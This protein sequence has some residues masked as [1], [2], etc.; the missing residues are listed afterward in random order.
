MKDFREL[1]LSEANLL[2]LRKK[3]FLEPTEIQA[4]AIPLLMK[5]KVDIIAQAQTGTGKTAAFALPLIEKL[6]PCGKVQALILAPTRELVLQICAEID[7]LKGENPMEVLPIYGGSPYSIQLRG[8]KSGPSIVVG[9]PGRI[10]DHIRRGTLVLEG[11][12]FFILDEAD[13]MLNMGFIEDI[14]TII[15]HTPKRKRTMLFSATM[16]NRIKRLASRYMGESAFIRSEKDMTTDLTEQIYFE[17]RAE[18]R[19]EALS[20]IL[21]L[22]KDFY[23]IVFCKTRADVDTVSA[24]LK[25][26][27]YKAEGLHGD[28]AQ[29][30]R[31]RIL[32]RFRDR[33]VQVLIATDVAARGIDVKDL[34][35]VVN[36]SMPQNP[37]SYV[38]RIGRTGR[39]GS[40][41][42][43]ITFVTPSENRKLGSIV[44]FIGSDIRRVNV[45]GRKEI[46]E[47]RI[48]SIRDG[49][50][51]G[52][53]DDE[54]RLLA[55]DLLSQGSAED[56]V[57]ELLRQSFGSKIKEDIVFDTP[58]RNRIHPDRQD[59]RP[60][61]KKYSPPE[62]KRDAPRG[63]RAR[64][65]KNERSNSFNS[66]RTHPGGR[67]KRSG[68]TKYRS[69]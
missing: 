28:I 63:D 27:G 41:G 21:D 48:N 23:G 9:T 47:K 59:K 62:F 11:I 8:L 5:N 7:S 2:T 26:R 43:A 64:P 44:R 39:A 13:E 31:E 25:D 17:V 32:A 37:E 54:F 15:G 24:R 49:I 12:E 35:H 68:P 14:E 10:L 66:H 55:R 61:F 53:I 4:M 38:H 65:G 22:E 69:R 3:G 34:T 67:K 60:P 50:R 58:R 6:H 29:P 30:T 51:S 52:D 33:Q 57:S 20:R 46:M 56:L 45:P 16:P 40:K 42:V 19:E 18:Q 1:G 36:H